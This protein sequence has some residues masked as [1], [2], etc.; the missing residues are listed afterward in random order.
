MDKY[1][2]IMLKEELIINN[3]Y[4]IHYF[5]YSKDYVFKGESHNF[6]E[7]LFVDSGVIEVTAG[8]QKLV[9]Q[10]GQIIFHEPGEFHALRANGKIAPNLIVVSFECSKPCMDFFRKKTTTLDSTEHFYLSTIISEARKTFYTPLNNPLVC[11]LQ[12]Y[13]DTEFGSEQ[14]IKTSLELFLIHI[15]RRLVPK[16]NAQPLVPPQ[17]KKNNDEVITQIRQYLSAHVYD[18]VTVA[19]ICKDNM[20][21][22]SRLQSI[23]HKYE[24]CGVID[25]FSRLKINMAKVMIREK[26]YNYTEIAEILGYS[27]YQYFSLQFKKYVRMSPSEYSSSTKIFAE[28]DA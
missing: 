24:G 18:H 3:I 28:K 16:G 9:L 20:I 27:S 26:K 22:K 25:Y 21:G 10:K 19:Q 1:E 14:I 23:F 11:K 7:F 8:N 6:W 5:E 12:R 13:T 2:S 17:V 15:L 4:S